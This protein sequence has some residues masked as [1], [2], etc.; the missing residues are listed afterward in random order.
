[1][2]ILYNM[3]LSYNLVV[4]K[5]CDWFWL[6][7]KFMM[8]YFD[9]VSVNWEMMVFIKGKC[10]LVYISVKIKIK[11]IVFIGEIVFKFLEKYDWKFD[12]ISN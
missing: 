12:F 5:E 7:Y 10:F 2:D 1:M 8:C 3:D 4:E 9:I 6:V 11:V